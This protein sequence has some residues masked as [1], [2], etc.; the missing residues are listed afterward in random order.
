MHEIPDHYRICL[1]YVL[2]EHAPTEVVVFEILDDEQ[3]IK[4]VVTPRLPTC[5]STHNLL[6]EAVVAA[7]ASASAEA[8]RPGGEAVARA[9]AKLMGVG[10]SQSPTLKSTDAITL[11][12]SVRRELA[13]SGVPATLAPRLAASIVTR[14]LKAAEG[15]ADE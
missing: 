9:I 6:P 15:R 2:S 11:T 13:D 8:A 1:Q 3:L 14:V 4:L 7:A 10:R 12:E 5:R